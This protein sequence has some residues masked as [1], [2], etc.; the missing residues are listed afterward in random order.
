MY[1]VDPEFAK[2]VHQTWMECLGNDLM[3]IVVMLAKLFLVRLV[4]FQVQKGHSH[5]KSKVEYK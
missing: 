1:A 3:C 4:L 5:L 2:E